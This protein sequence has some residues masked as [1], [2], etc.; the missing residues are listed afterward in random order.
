MDNL[1][2]HDENN[3]MDDGILDDDIEVIE[4]DEL[5]A[6]DEDWTDDEDGNGVQEGVNGGGINP[7]KDDSI[8]TMT[9]HKGQ[10]LSCAINSDGTLAVSGDQSDMAY[11]WNVQDGTVKFACSGHTDSVTCVGFNSKENLVATGDMKGSIQVWKIEDGEKIFEYQVDDLNW[12]KW[13]P[14]S[15]NVLLAG[16]DKGDSWMWN[17]KD[18]ASIKTYQGPNLSCGAADIFP[19]GQRAVMGYDDGSLR[20]WGLKDSQVL[21]S[22]T[23]FNAHKGQVL[24]VAVNHI[25][26]HIA[27]GSSDGT[28]KL[29]N[30]NGRV[31]ATW[32]CGDASDEEDTVESVAFCKSHPLL[33]TATVNGNLDIWDTSSTIKRHKIIVDSGISK[34]MWDPVNEHF[35]H[36]GGLDGILRTYDGR[37]GQLHSSRSGHADHILDFNVSSKTNLILTASED[38]TCKIFKFS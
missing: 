21:T 4:D 37:D 26:S 35:L 31:L 25:G 15:P 23:G 10:V 2:D 14:L 27:S 16:T 13:H 6:L 32:V 29:I 3:S 24:T 5:E 11:V 33:A 19:D 7:E 12:L 1:E 38:K 17:V 22:I 34:I 36:V 9:S 28:V 30:Q 20:I 18:I 8:L